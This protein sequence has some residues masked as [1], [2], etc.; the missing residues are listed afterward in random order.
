LWGEFHLAGF[1]LPLSLRA[2]P[3]VTN[4]PLVSLV[5]FV[6]SQL[7]RRTNLTFLQVVPTH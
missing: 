1:Q 6:S 4:Q 7:L 2:R 5:E 3:P